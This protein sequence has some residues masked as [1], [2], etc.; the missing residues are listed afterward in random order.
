VIRRRLAVLIFALA[1]IA[2]SACATFDQN[3]VAAKI[4]DRSLSAEAVQALATTGDTAATGDELRDQ[5]TKWIRVTVLE[6]SSGTAAPTSPPTS[7]EL[8]DRYALAITTLAG[9]Q[10]R[11]L[12]ESGVS[13]SP[14]VCLR[15]VTLP[16]IDEANEVLATVQAGM[17]L[18]DAARQFSTDTAVGATGGIVTGPDGNECL[19]PDNV[20]PAVTAALA[21]TPVGQVIAADLT[22]FSAVLMLRPWDDLLLESQS[23]IAGTVVSQEQLDAIVD[24]ADIYVDP[25]YGRWDPASGSVVALTS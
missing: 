7:A 18:A 13:G 22:T 1:S 15:A 25:R 3:D 17:P 19:A 2:L 10:A 8:D 20:L 14:V 11:T 12:Y 4:G 6:E 16:T 9:D 5:L 24:A 23:L 21:D